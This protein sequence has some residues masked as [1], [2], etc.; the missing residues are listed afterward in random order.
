M[1]FTLSRMLLPLQTLGVLTVADQDVI[2]E[3]ATL[4]PPHRYGPA[5]GP[6]KPTCIPAGTYPIAHRRPAQSARFDY[7][8]LIV[9]DVPGFTGVLV[10]S[11]NW[12]RDTT[13]CILPGMRFGQLDQGASRAEVIESR[14]ALQQLVGLLP[15][16]GAKLQVQWVHEGPLKACRKVFGA[17]FVAG[18]DLPEPQIMQDA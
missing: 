14:R 8:H 10:H 13:A 1:Q 12:T 3:F 16:Q 7:P 11:G 17:R 2:A 15:R 18:F 5:G 9:E 4:E 6:V